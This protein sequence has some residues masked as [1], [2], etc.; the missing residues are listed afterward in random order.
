MSV[1]AGAV[2]TGSLTPASC[3]AGAGIALELR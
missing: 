1:S 3:A 2:G